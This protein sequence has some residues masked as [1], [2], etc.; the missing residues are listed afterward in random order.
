MN[1]IVRCGLLIAAIASPLTLATA[2]DADQESSVKPFKAKWN[3]RDHIPLTEFTIQSHRG[4]GELAPENTLE[5]FELGWKLGTIPEADVRTT[6]DGVIV[7]FHD[8]NFSRV[9]RGIDAEMQKK[10]VSDISFDELSQLDVGAWLGDEFKGRRVSRMTD[11]YALMKQHPKR[12]LYLDHKDADLEQLASEVK[13]YDV[14]SQVILASS[15]HELLRQWKKLLPDSGTLLWIPGNEQH[16]RAA[17]EAARQ[18]DFDGITQLQIHVQMP[19][20]AADIQ[21]GE[22]FSPS[23]QFLAEVSSELADRG[24]L[25]QTLPYGATDAVTYTQLL[26]A[27]LASFATDYPNVTLKAV[28]DYYEAASSNSKDQ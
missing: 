18:T 26:D 4:A 2:Q 20:N 28:H 27:G 15:K 3:V 22:P 11:I 6:N 23:R 7:A 21:P 19:G 9:V 14:A 1:T 25:F 17:M 12:R 8:N 10:G 24:I 13:Q 16:K 5:A